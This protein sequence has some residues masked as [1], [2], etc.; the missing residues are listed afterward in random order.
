MHMANGG[1][2]RENGAVSIESVVGG[3]HAEMPTETAKKSKKPACEPFALAGSLPM[4]PTNLVEKILKGQYH[5]VDLSDLLQ[6]NTLLAKK[7]GC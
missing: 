3:V 6:D 5:D 7:S 1:G 4:I 2:D